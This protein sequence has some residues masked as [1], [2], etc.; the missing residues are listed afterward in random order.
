[1]R[2]HRRHHED[3]HRRGRHGRG[4][5]LSA[6]LLAM[7]AEAPSQGHDLLQALEGRGVGP[8]AIYPTLALLEDQG[9]IEAIVDAGKKRYQVTEAGRTALR[10]RDGMPDAIAQAVTQFGSVLRLRLSAGAVGDE[11]ATAIAAAVHT[12]STAIATQ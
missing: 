3:F 8:D 1:M 7:I 4:E 2:H 12:A 10:Q 6:R 11:A 9:L 5:D